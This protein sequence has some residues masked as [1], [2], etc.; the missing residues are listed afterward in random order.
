MKAVP[1]GLLLFVMATQS[2]PASAADK[3]VTA[4]VTLSLKK[5]RSRN[6]VLGGERDKVF[7]S[8]WIPAGVKTA[9]VDRDG[10]QQGQDRQNLQAA[11]P[12]GDRIG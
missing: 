1:V 11:Y 9:C 3:D 10:S 8:V 7:F 6:P 4:K 5:P 12:R 2:L